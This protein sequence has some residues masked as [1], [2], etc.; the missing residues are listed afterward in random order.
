[1]TSIVIQQCSA[2]ESP[3]E[4]ARYDG[5]PFGEGFEPFDLG[6]AITV[7]DVRGSRGTGHDL[8]D[9]CGGAPLR[10][11]ETFDYRPGAA[12][13]GGE[14]VLC[15]A[16]PGDREGVWELLED[17][18]VGHGPRAWARVPQSRG[19]V[20]LQDGGA[21]GRVRVERLRLGATPA[22]RHGARPPLSWPPHPGR[23]HMARLG[24]WQPRTPTPSPAPNR[25]R[26]RTRTRTRTPGRGQRRGCDAG[27]ERRGRGR[28]QSPG[29]HR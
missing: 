9:N 20:R 6:H 18:S 16:S 17:G 12:R 5:V 21:G 27:A 24:R 8:V 11:Q 29:A 23:R 15:S 7:T 22:Q 14:L 2:D 10:L 25:R 3:T 13:V 4:L 1:M 26:T 28:A 19:R